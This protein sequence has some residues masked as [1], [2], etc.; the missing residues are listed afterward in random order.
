VFGREALALAESHEHAHGIVRACWALGYLCAVKGDL[1]PAIQWWERGLAL[2][3]EVDRTVPAVLIGA[4]L[5]YVYALAG[6]TDECLARLD[7]AIAG[8]ESLRAGGIVHSLMGVHL[9]EAGRL[10]RHPAALSLAKRALALACERGQRVYEADALR[11]LAE[12][13]PSEAR[14]GEAMAI[15]TEL[16][17]RPLAAHCHAG[18]AKLYRDLGKR[19]ESDA[20]FTTA[21]TMYRAMGMTYWLEQTE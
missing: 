19:Q 15:A 11:V 7:D 5:C 12:L 3:R 20:R 8:H 21:T 2:S 1:V 16:G 9:A 10:T 4:S 13:E 6:R 18:L 14:W 17:L